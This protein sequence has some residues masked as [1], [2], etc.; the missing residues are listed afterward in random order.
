[1]SGSV[2]PE[3][4]QSNPSL[5]LLSTANVERGETGEEAGETVARPPLKSPDFKL[6]LLDLLCLLNTRPSSFAPNT[7]QAR[8]TASQQ[9]HRPPPH[10]YTTTS[11]PGNARDSELWFNMSTSSSSTA[12]SGLGITFH[13][14]PIEPSSPVAQAKATLYGA[15]RRAHPDQQQRRPQSVS[16]DINLVREREERQHRDIGAA[17]VREAS[18]DSGQRR[19]RIAV[20]TPEVFGGRKDEEQV[21]HQ[22]LPQA[23]S[24]FSSSDLSSSDSQGCSPASLSSLPSSTNSAS[25]YQPQ[26]YSHHQLRHAQSMGALPYLAPAPNPYPPQPRSTQPYSHLPYDSPPESQ[27]SNESRSSRL[28]AFLRERTLK[29]QALSRPKSMLELG[30]MYALQSIERCSKVPEMVHSSR[31]YGGGVGAERSYGRPE[32]GLEQLEEEDEEDSQDQRYG[33]ESPESMPSSAGGLQRRQLERQLHM[34][35]ALHQ[36]E[37]RRQSSNLSLNKQLPAHPTVNRQLTITRSR[38]ASAGASLPGREPIHPR[39]RPQSEHVKMRSFS[40]MQ[41]LEPAETGGSFVQLDVLGQR[42]EEGEEIDSRTTSDGMR[43]GEETVVLD[44]SAN[45]LRRSGTV[46]AKPRDGALGRQPTLLTAGANPSR[47]S[48]ELDRLL[49]PTA[50]KIGSSLSSGGLA[51][52]AGSP[53]FSASSN[54]AASTHQRASSHSSSYAPAVLTTPVSLE[55]AKSTS[56]ARVELDLVL[57]SSLVVEGGTL[58]GRMEVRIRKPKDRE[59]EVWVGKPKIR[60]IGF[61]GAFFLARSPLDPAHRSLTLQ[62]SLRKTPA[63]FSTTT[64]RPSP[65]SAARTAQHCL[66]RASTPTPIRRASPRASLDSTPSPSACFS[67]SVRAPRA[68][69]RASRALCGTSSSRASLPSLLL[70]RTLTKFVHRSVKL[71]S[72]DGSDRSIA[73]FYRHVEIF[74]YFSPAVVLAPALRPLLVTGSKALFMG[75]NGKVTLT[76]KMHRGT[77]VAG[78]RCYVDVNVENESSKKVRQR[79]LRVLVYLS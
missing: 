76:A 30:E 45:D 74:P 75:G 17:M 24:P 14:S 63:T 6:F 65:P 13:P 66:C 31:H 37:L 72:E 67:P 1:M 57:Q 60:V 21:Y 9:P 70:E 16:Y 59:R 78:Q 69:S 8:P 28:P 7:R 44:D 62:N 26:Y 38:S 71:K 56:K 10:E 35:H 20:G 3:L 50:K 47:R 27:S 29:K 41:G 22:P 43:M 34:Q 64:P 42:F 51:T 61:E 49:A 23:L 52:I 33:D 15:D 40:S 36:E 58:K 73:H 55:Q 48:K 54:I 11:C 5:S 32:D 79:A 2:C 77:W 53:T 68:V 12:I 4:L 39:P 25:A 18:D 19:V 46:I